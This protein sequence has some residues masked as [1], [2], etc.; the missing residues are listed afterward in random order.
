M[1]LWTRKNQF[2]ELQFLSKIVLSELR[3]WGAYI[4]FEVFGN[5]TFMSFLT[6]PR[7]KTLQR[8]SAS[9]LTLKH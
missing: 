7:R 8:C 2:S 5:F 4:S 3:A 1:F 6:H 9:R